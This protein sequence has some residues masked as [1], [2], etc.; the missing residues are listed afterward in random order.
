[1]DVPE[2]VFASVWYQSE[3]VSLLFVEEKE[4]FTMPPR[5]RDA[6]SPDLEDREMP[7]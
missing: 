2:G 1:V 3:G 4:K 5:R 6:Q 7:R